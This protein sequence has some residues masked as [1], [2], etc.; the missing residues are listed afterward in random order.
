[1]N[2]TRSAFQPSLTR[3][4]ICRKKKCLG[5]VTGFRTI[6]TRRMVVREVP[7]L[8]N[9]SWVHSCVT[10]L[11]WLW[12]IA[13]FLP[14][15][16]PLCL[17]AFWWPSFSFRGKA[18]FLLRPKDSMESG[19]SLSVYDNALHHF[20]HSFH[21]MD[22]NVLDVPQISQACTCFWAFVFAVFSA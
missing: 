6:A 16:F 18:S 9:N 1:M 21:Y 10:E 22:R 15:T 20:F 8:H 3:G 5:W 7:L 13:S 14:F 2:P 19:R 12:L 11:L 4:R 17:K